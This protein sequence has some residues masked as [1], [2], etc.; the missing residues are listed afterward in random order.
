M[1]VNHTL[2]KYDNINDGNMGYHGDDRYIKE[3]DEICSYEKCSFIVDTI[4]IKAI[5]GEKRLHD[6]NQT[7]LKIIKY[8]YNNYD[9]VGRE[10]GFDF[11]SN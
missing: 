10:Y 6:T 7:S 9:L 2:N 1:N 5:N 3:I 4:Y 8:V 11:Y